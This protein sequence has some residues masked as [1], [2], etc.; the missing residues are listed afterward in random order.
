M[1]N[2]Y[3]FKVNNKNDGMY[4]VCSKLTR[5][6]LERHQRVHKSTSRY[7]KILQHRCFPVNIAKFLRT[8]FLQNISGDCFCKMMKFYEDNC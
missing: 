2:N 3:M 1:L 4:R 7:T 8:P 6:K 5:N